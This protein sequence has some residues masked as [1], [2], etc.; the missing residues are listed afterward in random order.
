MAHVVSSPHKPLH[1]MLD[2]KDLT[3][4]ILRVNKQVYAESYEAMIKGNRFVHVCSTGGVHFAHMLKAHNVPT[5][6]FDMDDGKK[7]VKSE[8]KIIEPVTQRFRGYA[9]RITIGNKSPNWKK[10]LTSSELLKPG[11]FMMLFRD[12]ELLCQA[13]MAG[14]ERLPDYWGVLNLDINV[15]PVATHPPFQ[16]DATKYFSQLHEALLEPFRK[17][18]R[19]LQRVTIG[20]TAPT[21]LVESALRDF[22]WDKFAD[23]DAL[24]ES[25]AA[26]KATGTQLFLQGNDEL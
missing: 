3:A 9:L 5:L 25:W 18:I 21:A 1:T 8:G 17:E 6:A 24:I 16:L 10:L 15:A 22:F 14:D 13:I 19:G 4:S 7:E 26:Q 23:P 2:K 20:G 11:H 12:V